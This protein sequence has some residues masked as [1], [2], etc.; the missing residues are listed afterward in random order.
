MEIK[1]LVQSITILAAVIAL[2]N[3]AHAWTGY[4]GVQEAY[5]EG[6]GSSPRIALILSQPFH[7]CGWNTVGNIELSVVGDDLFKVFNAAILTA[8]SSGK[9]IAVFV[10]GCWGD[11]AKIVAVKLS[12]F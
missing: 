4:I 10:D 12:G 3:I 6:V 11:R 5:F 7:N 2:P 9:P 8:V 1:R